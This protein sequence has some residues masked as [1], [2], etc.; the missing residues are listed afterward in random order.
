[1]NLLSYNEFW[2]YKR[3]TTTITTTIT[4]RITSSQKEMLILNESNSRSFNE[5][6]LL[7]LC[8][9]GIFVLASIAGF[10]LFCVFKYCA[11]SKNLFKKTVLSSRRNTN[12]MSTQYS[13]QLEEIE[14]NKVEKPSPEKNMVRD[15]S[16]NASIMEV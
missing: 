4:T 3:V 14:K 13:V 5:I 15:K 1:M 8:L 10:I 11:C 6:L 16:Y 2:E 12:T 7:C 9:L